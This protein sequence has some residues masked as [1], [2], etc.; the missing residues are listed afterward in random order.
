M[1]S[2]PTDRQGETASIYERLHKDVRLDSGRVASGAK[3]IVRFD[4]VPIGFIRRER[5]TRRGREGWRWVGYLKSVETP[6]R[7]SIGTDRMACAR[8]V[9]VEFLRKRKKVC[10]D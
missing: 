1:N 2:K 9:A 10:D 4:G 8:A 7:D 6:L 5:V 3:N